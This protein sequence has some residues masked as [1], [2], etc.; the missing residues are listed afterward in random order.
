[1][2]LFAL[3]DDGQ[4]TPIEVADCDGQPVLRLRRGAS[5]TDRLVRELNELVDR[6]GPPIERRGGRPVIIVVA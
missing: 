6:E 3:A 1:M 5:I 2:S 4:R